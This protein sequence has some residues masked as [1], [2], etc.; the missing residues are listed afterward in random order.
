MRKTITCITCPVGCSI[1][2]EYEGDKIVSMKGNRCP[3]GA[4]YARSEVLHPSRVLTTAVYVAAAGKM[5]PVRSDRP[6][7]KE[8]LRACVAAAKKLTVTPPV[9]MGDV[10]MKEIAEGVNLIASADLT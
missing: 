5:L 7:P 1:D 4:E 10:L 2:V 9:R 8:A 6:V 3:R